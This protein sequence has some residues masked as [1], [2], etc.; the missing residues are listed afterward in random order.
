MFGDY[1]EY[2]LKIL[3]I[4]FLDTLRTKVLTQE[5]PANKLREILKEYDNR[6]K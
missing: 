4:N 3:N 5:I 1:N 6:D 2:R